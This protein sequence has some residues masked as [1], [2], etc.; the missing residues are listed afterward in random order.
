MG[1]F[2]SGKRPIRWRGFAIRFVLMWAIIFLGPWLTFGNLVFQREYLVGFG[3]FVVVA[4]A[5]GLTL[6]AI[7]R[8]RYLK[9]LGAK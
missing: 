1:E 8:H 9:E 7:R 5:P 2:Y 6:H 3:V 4:T